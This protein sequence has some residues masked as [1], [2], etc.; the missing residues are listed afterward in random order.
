VPGSQ[1]R[2]SLHHSIRGL[3][4]NFID[5][6]RAAI[7]CKRPLSVEGLESTIG[8]A[9]S[10][11][12]KDNADLSLIAVSVSRL[13]NSGDPDAIPRVTDLSAAQ[14]YLDAKGRQIADETHRFWKGKLDRAGI[15]FYAFTP[16]SW[17]MDNGR[18]NYATFRSE[19]M[20]PVDGADEQTKALL[21]KLGRTLKA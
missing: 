3:I 18:F 21:A 7:Q 9:I 10:Q 14:A 11:L 6:L 2:A 20:C 1:R 19:T 8:S 17:L 15:I 12:K 13:W 16:I 5:G 4:C